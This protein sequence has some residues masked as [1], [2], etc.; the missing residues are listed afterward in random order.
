MSINSSVSETKTRFDLETSG[1]I[2]LK[3]SFSDETYS[4]DIF[5]K[6]CTNLE[7]IKPTQTLNP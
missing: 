1:M 7:S 5:I 2:E 6:K 4:L 3:V